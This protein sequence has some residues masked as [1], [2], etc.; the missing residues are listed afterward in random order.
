MKLTGML[1]V[2]MDGYLCLRGVASIKDLDDISKIDPKIQRDLLKKH[3]EEMRDF[4]ES[5]EYVFFP[6]VILSMS[7]GVSDDKDDY[8][9]FVGIVNTDE[10][11][12]NKKVG[13]IKV[14]F[15]ADENKLT[16]GRRK[17]KVA[18]FEFSNS[19]VTINR[20]DGN[21]RLSA[22]RYITNDKLI[23]FCLI[24]FPNDEEARN[25][26]RAIFHNINS[27]Q[28]PLELEHSTKIIIES[29]TVFP[30]NA[31]EKK[32]PF[33]LHYLFARKLLCDTNKLDFSYFPSIKKLVSEIKYSFFTNLFRFLLEKKLIEKEYAVSEL[34]GR[35]V[36]I[37][38]ALK[39]EEIIAS[40]PNSSIVGAMAY[41][42]FSSKDKYIHF[43]K[44]VARNHIVDAKA[45][46]LDDIINIFDKIYDSIPKKVFL[47]RWYPEETDEEY[48][49]AEHRYKAISDA[50]KAFD[51]KLELIDMGKRSRGTFSIREAIDL[52]LPKSDVFIADLTGARPNVMVEVGM[53]LKNIPDG[54]ML[55]YFKPTKSVERVP[56]DLGD[57]QY[58]EIA[59]SRDID[60]KVVPALRNIINNLKCGA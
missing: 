32:Q 13:S 26:S 6:E 57:Y 44:W 39:D 56:F 55:F 37:E 9:E 29:E 5:G 35:L 28:I 43:I 48:S 12:F 18:Q 30:D 20:I 34:Q 16:D 47:A 7:V 45:V 52:E 23:P 53:A 50:I 51:P 27:K 1:S 36:G 25:H 42:K 8:E 24:V 59:D 2:I 3:K 54:R 60:S 21:H 22:A 46:A 49:D 40:S 58:H 41:Y 15:R 11:G 38:K 17:V 19:D 4:L 10:K 31:F 33:G 14:N